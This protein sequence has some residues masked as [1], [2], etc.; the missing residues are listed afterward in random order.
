MTAAM[1][2]GLEL[3]DTPGGGLTAVV[4]L[5]SAMTRVLCVDD[6]PQLLRTLG[7]NLKARHYD[8]DLAMT[9]EQASSWP[10]PAGPTSWCSTSACPA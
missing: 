2:G 8:V 7:A 1:G 9:G 3:W 10:P 5:G 4:S 6:E